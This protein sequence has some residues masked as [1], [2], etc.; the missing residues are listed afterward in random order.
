MKAPDRIANSWQLL[1]AVRLFDHKTAKKELHSAL[2]LAAIVGRSL[3]PRSKR[4]ENAVLE[5]NK[6]QS[7]LIS[8]PFGPNSNYRIGLSISK[9]SLGLYT[10]DLNCVSTLDLHGK[11][12]SGVFKWLNEQIAPLYDQV[13][14]LSPDLPYSLPEL[15]EELGKTFNKPSQEALENIEACFYNF[16]LEIEQI[17]F[18]SDDSSEI[19]CWPQFFDLSTEICLER[20]A[21]GLPLKTISLGFSPGDNINEEPYLFVN[22]SPATVIDPRELPELEG[23]ASWMSGDWFGII[24]SLSSVYSLH[25]KTE[26]EL[27]ANNFFKKA[28]KLVREMAEAK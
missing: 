9:F 6:K 18:L 23:K 16:F 4:D 13:I 11:P 19:L 24:L 7:A 20:N 10:A 3:L 25:S 27:E 5:W 14:F 12:Q 28:L 8:R 26:Q 15:E 17:S 1:R 2:Q 21:K 22:L